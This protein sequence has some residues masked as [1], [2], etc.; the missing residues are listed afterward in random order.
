MEK[1]LSETA[2]VNGTGKIHT[3]EIFDVVGCPIRFEYN[4]FFYEE[5]I[6]LLLNVYE[7]IITIPELKLNKLFSTTGQFI[8]NLPYTNGKDGLL[9]SYAADIMTDFELKGVNYIGKFYIEKD[10]CDRNHYCLN[11]TYKRNSIPDERIGRE[12][13]NLAFQYT[14]SYKKGCIELT[15]T[16]EKESISFLETEK[17]IPPHSNLDRIFIRDDIKE[18]IQRFIYTFRNFDKFDFPLRYLL[19]GK[20]GLGKTEIVRTV[21]EKCSDYGIVIIPKNM[22]GAEWLSFEFAKLF[23][24]SVICIDD[25]DLLF[26]KRE[27][28]YTRKTLG[29]FL[30]ALDGILE[31]KVF[32]IATTNDKKLV[33]IAASRPG[34]FDEIID[35][36][37]FERKYFMDLIN[38]RTQDENIINLFDEEVL[39]YMDSRK[40]TGAFIVNLIKQMKIMIEINPGFDKS[41]LLSYLQKS[42][43]GFYKSQLKEEKTIGF[44]E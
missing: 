39:D 37:D 13:L 3:T 31:N 24:P 25:I 9:E 32:I 4:R 42:Y 44:G 6:K 33:D 8:C 11:F 29:K 12:L 28:G 40:V 5:I 30:N 15:F 19:S 35:F 41:N 14:Y 43:K 18:D 26:G 1:E 10:R 38:Q 23:K 20:P 27:E 17:V 22:D 34:R 2:Y 36:G 16:G 7:N 21:I